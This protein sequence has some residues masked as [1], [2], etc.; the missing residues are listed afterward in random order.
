MAN[1]FHPT[2]TIGKWCSI[3]VSSRGTDTSIGANSVLDD[4]VK[5][6]HV[7]GIGNIEIGQFVYIN[8]G[9]VLYS[10]NGIKIGNN[11]LIGPNCNL[12]PVNHQYSNPERI[13]RS[14]GFQPSRG[15][16]IIEDD[17]WLGANVTLLDGAIIRR[18]CVIG[19]NSL[20]SSDT[21]EYGIYAGI[22]AKKIKTRR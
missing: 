4:F 10:G 19:A 7:G 2:C 14:Q 17:V 1:K 3:E 18:G 22:P 21:D 15:G 5:I 12:M 8:S 16:I 6:K 13:I 20:V 9:T 11:V